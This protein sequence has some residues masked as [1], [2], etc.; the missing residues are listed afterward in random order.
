ME[1]RPFSINGLRA[2]GGG[3]GAL[4]GQRQGRRVTKI[5]DRCQQAVVRLARKTEGVVNLFISVY[6]HCSVWHTRPMKTAMPANSY[7][8]H[9]FPAEI[10]SHAIWLYF[11]FCLSNRGVEEL[12]FARG[13]TV[14]YEA[15]RKWCRKFGQSYA[16][17]CARRCRWRRRAQREEQ[18]AFASAL[19]ALVADW[20]EDWELLCGDEATGRRHPTLTARWCLADEVPE[21]P[22][23]DDHAKV[24]VYGAVA[25]LIGRTHAQ[26]SPALGTGAFAQ[27]LAHVL[28]YHPGN[29][30]L[31]IHARGEQHQGTPVDAVVREAQGRRVLKAQPAYAPELTPQERIWQW[32][33]R[34]VTHHHWFASLGEQIEAIRNF[35]RYLAGVTDQVRR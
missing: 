10:I 32:L 13:V 15:I 33:R 31:V 6:R 23:G 2:Q 20:P 1:Y 28:T 17:R 3:V 14:T 26:I 4:R 11:R 29:H 9:R 18:A 8:N 25:P 35:F 21:V 5:V 12:L 7:K 34:V 24:P 30:R 16:N 22:T 27:C 19:E